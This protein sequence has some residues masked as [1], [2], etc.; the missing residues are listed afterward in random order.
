MQ[1]SSEF[2]L[3]P[4]AQ[5][6]QDSPTPGFCTTLWAAGPTVEEARVGFL[7]LYSGEIKVLLKDLEV[8]LQDWSYSVGAP[9]LF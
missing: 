9:S 3:E 4:G 1:L 2:Y 7:S 8:Y 5:G 6:S